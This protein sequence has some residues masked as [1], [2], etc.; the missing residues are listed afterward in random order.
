MNKKNKKK[1]KSDVD[2]MSFYA[3]NYIVQMTRIHCMG[4]WMWNMKRKKNENYPQLQT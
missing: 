3:L 4:N 1:K 2:E